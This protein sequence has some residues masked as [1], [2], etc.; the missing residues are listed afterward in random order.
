M[1]VPTPCA[2]CLPAVHEYNVHIVELFNA[3]RDQVIVGFSGPLSI[4]D[5][6]LRGAMRDYFNVDKSQMLKL[7]LRVRNLYSHV[8]AAKRR[9]ED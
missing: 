3:C 8:L 9:R 5:I 4:D 1:E 7:S 2:T 6:N